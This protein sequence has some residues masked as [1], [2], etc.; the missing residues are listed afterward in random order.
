MISEKLA[1]AERELMKVR[2]E[3]N[4]QY[5][6]FT[7]TARGRPVDPELRRNE[8]AIMDRISVLRRDAKI[9]P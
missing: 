9:A 8:Q 4:R 1:A 3:I 6:L 5:W 7:R 2:D